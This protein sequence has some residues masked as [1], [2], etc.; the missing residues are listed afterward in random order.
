MTDHDVI[1]EMIADDRA[2]RSLR[3]SHVI[4]F[5]LTGFCVLVSMVHLLLPQAISPFQHLLAGLMIGRLRLRSSLREMS[6]RT[7]WGMHAMTFGEAAVIRCEPFDDGDRRFVLSFKHSIATVDLQNR[8]SYRLH[9]E[10][11]METLDD[12]NPRTRAMIAAHLYLL[13]ASAP[14]AKRRRPFGRRS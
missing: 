13:A 14:R 11:C 10:T 7:I 4:V 9:V 1:E 6:R 3:R 2:W 8:E 12:V 5:A